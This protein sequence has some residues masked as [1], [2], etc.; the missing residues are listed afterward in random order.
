M[1]R[2]DDLYDILFRTL[3]E[4]CEHEPAEAIF[5]R[6]VDEFA[7]SIEYHTSQ[8]DT[9]KVMLDT[10]RHDNPVDTVPHESAEDPF[11]TLSEL[12][13]SYLLE[14][15]DKLFDFMKNVKFPDRLDP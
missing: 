6:I 12:N 11:N 3:V 14:D 10:F 7:A 13:R 15:R 4:L 5:D 1:S 9:F 2:R 8:A